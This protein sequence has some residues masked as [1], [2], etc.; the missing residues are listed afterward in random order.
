MLGSGRAAKIAVAAGGS[1]IQ[2]ESGDRQA[3]GG[4]ES[5]TGGTVRVLG[6]D[7]GGTKTALAIGD[8]TGR[9]LA[10]RRRPTGCTG[11]WRRDV[12]ALVDDARALA[13]EAD[14]AVGDLAAAGLSVPGPLDPE[15]QALV[16]PPNLPGWDDVPLRDVIA[17]RLGVPVWIENDANAAGLAEWR[18][19]AGQGLSD[20]VFLTMSTGVGG[21][22]VLGG[23]LHRGVA[24]SAGE[25]GHAPLV[26]DGEPCACG[27]RGCLEA[28]VGGAA[29]TRRLRAIAP[30]ASLAAQLAGGVPGLTPRHVVQAARRGDAFAQ[31]EVARWV[32]HLG[33]ALV[34]LAF[35]L[36]PQAFVLGTI[37]VAAGEELCFAPLRRTLARRLWPGLARAV[38]V[39]P[40]ALGEELP[41]R[42]GLVVA[43]EG[44]AGRGAEPHGPTAG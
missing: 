17:E 15:R 25:I 24:W 1:E 44:L 34:G 21:G 26:W 30:E 16:S 20:L 36:A 11:D 19:G 33:R 39:L 8:G 18:S 31:A 28:Y 6:I 13:A 3:A 40:A 9:I 29:W 38:R 27:L 43:W 5:R 10:R 2:R 42:A 35:T 12:S 22:V 4:S 23:R 37:A 41:Y 14:V 32:E 7:V